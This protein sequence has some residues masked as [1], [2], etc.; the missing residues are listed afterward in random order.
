MPHY[1]ELMQTLSDDFICRKRQEWCLLSLP[2]LHA[3][4]KYQAATTR[5]DSSACPQ[6]TPLVWCRERSILRLRVVNSGDRTQS[7]QMSQRV[8]VLA[9][10]VLFN[11]LSSII[12]VIWIQNWLSP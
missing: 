12:S 4:A 7:I 8:V 2:K 11:E 1:I 3:F 5:S 6:G 9:L 10:A